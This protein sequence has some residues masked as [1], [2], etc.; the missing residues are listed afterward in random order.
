MNFF[1]RK[2]CHNFHF[3]IWYKYL[4][5]C[6]SGFFSSCC[7]LKLFQLIYAICLLFRLLRTRRNTLSD[8]QNIIASAQRYFVRTTKYFCCKAETIF[9][10]EIDPL[11]RRRG[12]FPDKKHDIL[13]E[14]S[15]FAPKKCPFYMRRDILSEQQSTSASKQRYIVR[16]TKCLCFKAEVYCQSNKVLLLQSREVLSK[17]Q[18]TSALKQR[19]A[20]GNNMVNPEIRNISS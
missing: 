7:C 8:Q 15:H 2:I 10:P 14:Q 1:G 5:F 19:Y 16:A 20:V 6:Q 11:R 18:S 13:A 9:T 12:S 3:L 4:P 17:Q